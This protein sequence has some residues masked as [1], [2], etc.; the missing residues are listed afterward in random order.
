MQAAEVSNIDQP[1]AL[2]Q[3]PAVDLFP[4]CAMACRYAI[5]ELTHDHLSDLTQ[6][7]SSTIHNVS[8]VCAMLRRTFRAD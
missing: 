2:V 7:T 6:L 1:S 8:S 5:A 3:P 4:H